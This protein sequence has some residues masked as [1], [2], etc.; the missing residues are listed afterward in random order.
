[1]S[2]RKKNAI[3]SVNKVQ[4]AIEDGTPISG[5]QGWFYQ[6]DLDCYIPVTI[7]G[8][9]MGD[10]DH[11]GVSLVCEIRGAIGPVHIA[12]CEFID[13]KKAIE[14]F[15]ETKER[16]EAANLVVEEIFQSPLITIRR[17]RLKEYIESLPS[18]IQEKL[19][20][21]MSDTKSSFA[22]MDYNDLRKYSVAA[23]IMANGLNDGDIYYR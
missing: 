17:K 2:S 14:S 3:V 9:K 13:D 19:V 15:R 16:K 22:K 6:E 1:M 20:T 12:P 8:I 5:I 10:K 23:A 4:K 21:D 18:D 11:C 7:K